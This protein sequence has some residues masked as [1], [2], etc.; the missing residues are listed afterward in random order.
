MEPVRPRPGGAPP[1]DATITAFED[2][3]RS[4]DQSGST[5][6]TSA[7][8][9]GSSSAGDGTVRLRGRLARP[10]TGYEKYV[11]G[12]ELGRG[13]MG[14][15]CRVLDI[16][17]RRDIAMKVM[18][19][20][21]RESKYARF[22]EEAQVTGQ[23]EHPNIVPVHALGLNDEGQPFFTMKLVDGRP[24]DSILDDLRADVP[25]VRRAWPLGR[26][27]AAF[28]GICNGI[29]YAH[30]HGVVHRDLKPG[31]IML[32]GFGEVLVMDWGLAKIGAVRHANKRVQSLRDDLI[33]RETHR[34][35]R[36]AGSGRLPP[37]TA[38]PADAEAVRQ[39]DDS[40]PYATQ[41][42]D[43]GG[44][45]THDGSVMGTP[46]YMPPEQ[47][48][49]EVSAIDERSDV[50][51]LGA[52]LYEILTLQPPVTGDTAKQILD[53]VRAGEI[54]PPDERSPEREIPLE[55][56]AI[57][58]KALAREPENRYQTVAELQQDLDLF[59]AGRAVSAKEDSAWETITKLIKRNKPVS[60]AI[61]IA[62]SLLLVTV[63]TAF[64]VVL[65]YWSQAET[66]R[67]EAR[68]ALA[69]AEASRD[70]ARRALDD[71]RR[72]QLLRTQAE[73]QQQE[74]EQQ[75]A[76][77]SRRNWHLVHEERFGSSLF[78]DWRAT[79]GWTD[80]PR[81]LDA[82]DRRDLI[83]FR[84][85]GLHI[86]HDSDVL[87][88]VYEHDLGDSIRLSYAFTLNREDSSGLH[89]VLRGDTWKRGYVFQV[90]GWDNT[91]AAILRGS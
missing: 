87:H 55:L 34:H 56:S 63:A 25:R 12:E 22:I 20:D 29:A 62:A 32:G 72:E 1:A 48:R 91:R 74:L 80:E 16:D 42:T 68:Q 19:P 46:V 17:L 54:L 2:G 58:M 6:G 36:T 40:D 52:I 33:R 41:M 57:T 61:G 77:E 53:R 24:M 5:G 35:Q 39:L 23:L 27:L 78:D 75:V 43:R 31:N 73:R 14:A 3:T 7:G 10:H 60:W 86:A 21:Q 51:S 89:A 70:R 64:S 9:R 26:L 59:S 30:D 15:V 76:R 67:D 88:L 83:R 50:Y 85:D 8:S 45:M 4:T 71:Y 44:T 37:A 84:P 69:A 49:G 47:A 79:Q 90:G 65:Q 38:T 11:A 28:G 13:G 82:A 18:L 66:S 81:V